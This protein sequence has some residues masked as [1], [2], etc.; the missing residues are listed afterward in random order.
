[1]SACQDMDESLTL[2]ATGALEPQ[3]ETRVRAHLDTCAACRREVAALQDTLGLAALPAPSSREQAILEALPQTTLG[4]WRRDQV[5]RAVH[6]RT[7]GLLMAAAAVLLLLVGPVVAPRTPSPSAPQ[8]SPSAASS[9]EEDVLALEQWA[10]A[11]PLSDA[12]DL[13]DADLEDAPEATGSWDVEADDL[14]YS[15]PFGDAL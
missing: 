1:M 4:R 13:T 7:T 11:D 9:T 2:L 3:E 14:L 8:A 10:Q 15:T 6:L 12:L 5:R